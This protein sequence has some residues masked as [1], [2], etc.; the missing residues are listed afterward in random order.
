MRR[1]M[2]DVRERFFQRAR[3]SDLRMFNARVREIS[4][5][6]NKWDVTGLRNASKAMIT[7]CKQKEDQM[8]K[9]RNWGKQNRAAMDRE[10][11]E[12]CLPWLK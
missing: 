5:L 11:A 2:V 12:Y 10:Y 8:I 9:P 6:A 3:P 1:Y 7:L 4:D